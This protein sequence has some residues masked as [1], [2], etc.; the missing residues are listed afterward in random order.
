MYDPKVA[1]YE[2]MN[3]SQKA[4]FKKVR[5]HKFSDDFGGCSANY[6]L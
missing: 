2:R 4:G 6:R 3:S 1:Y 5:S